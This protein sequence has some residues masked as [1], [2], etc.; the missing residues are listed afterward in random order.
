M[1]ALQWP[2]DPTPTT[3]GPYPSREDLGLPDGCVCYIKEDIDWG[4]VRTQPRGG[5]P[6]HSMAYGLD[7]LV[8][9]WRPARPGDTPGQLTPQLGVHRSTCVDSHCPGCARGRP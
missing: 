6:I 2:D 7:E 3:G 9:T 1:N 8:D 5:C 4:D